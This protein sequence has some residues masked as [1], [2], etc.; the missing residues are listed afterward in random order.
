MVKDG[1]HQ[2]KKN[3]QAAP[4][5]LKSL[6]VVVIEFIQLAEARLDKAQ[7]AADNV[8]ET[9]DDLEGELSPEA[10]LLSAVSTEDSKDRSDRDLI[11]PSLRFLWEAY[12]TVLDLLR[13]NTKL[14]L[15]YHKIVLQA[16]QFCLKFNRKSEFHRLCDTLRQHIQS[17]TNY[18]KQADYTAINYIDLSDPDT[19]QRFLELRFQQLNYSVKLE[20]WQESFRSIEDVHTLLTASKR[21]PK[22][23]MMV[24]YFENLAKVFAVSDNGLFHAAAYQ[25]HFNL[26]SQS[27]LATEEQLKHY[28]SLYLLSAL[29]IP[30]VAGDEAANHE[31]VRSNN[32]RLA[33]LLNLQ[34]VPTRDLILSAVTSRGILKIVDPE[35]KEL[36]KLLEDDFHPIT[37]AKKIQPAFNAIESNKAF[38]VYVKPLTQIVLT[39]LF[40]QL[41]EVYE[42]IRLDFLIKLCTFEGAFALSAV[43]IE[44]LLV[45]AAQ[46]GYI[47]VKIDHAAAVVSFRSD[48]F[49]DLIA[50][51]DNLQS[52]PAELVQSFLANLAKTLNDAS[53]KIYSGFAEERSAAQVEALQ[54]ANQE[55]KSERAEIVERVAILEKRDTDLQEAQLLK[56]Q[57]D[58]KRRLEKLAAD[59]KAEAERKE[60]ESLK[61]K[62][63]KIQKQQE[64]IKEQEIK[65][66]AEEINA[67]GIIKIDIDNLKDIDPD[68]LRKLQVQE[69]AKA[70]EDLEEKL[71]SLARRLSHTERAYRK[72]ELPLL[73]ENAEQQI[74]IDREAYEKSRQKIIEA[75]KKEH[76]KSLLLRDRL[77]RV[78]PDY[79]SFHEVALGKKHD[80]HEKIV[81]AAQAK[82]EKAKQE[83][84]EK[85]RAERTEI[86]VAKL[87]AQKEEE[88]R[89]KAEE[90]KHREEEE[91]IA[92]VAEERRKRDEAAAQRREVE[93]AAMRKSSESRASP[94]GR[95]QPV[96][97]PPA[98]AP[99]SATPTPP[100]GDKPMTFA[101]KML[102]RRKQ[103]E[104][105]GR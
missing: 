66:V 13:N 11:T 39:K 31:F 55:F 65:R 81:A 90:A 91:R 36:F 70:K 9:E 62:L 101:E 10:I 83:R 19:L 52:T 6:E 4:A 53:E 80:E 46:K 69:L 71:K 14:E 15:A 24:N 61:R 77:K 49:E 37:F 82:L 38:A 67:K 56:E 75:A 98:Q 76:E 54:L 58:E 93:A 26:F 40:Q 92:K 41:S 94:F 1:L 48:P 18:L 89:I 59:R 27:P 17:A 78:I 44:R 30:Q 29:S 34:T 42:T 28:A 22:P 85:I 7:A 33:S 8:E 43:Q 87:K 57:E 96:S 64:A 105:A 88:D 73:T 20:L 51:S 79:E 12:R 35:L 2:Y 21:Q 16:F 97:Q 99:V 100:A 3:I 25:K 104:S 84:L 72:H 47:S 50:S 45:D 5:G 23:Q 60:E 68:E 102:L 63:E 32:A 74:Q 103:R 95:A 86:L